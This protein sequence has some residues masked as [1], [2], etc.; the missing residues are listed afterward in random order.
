VRWVSLADLRAEICRGDITDG[1]TVAALGAA[2]MRD[3]VQF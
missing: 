1:F 3:I 2:A